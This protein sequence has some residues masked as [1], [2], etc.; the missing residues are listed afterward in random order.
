MKAVAAE[1]LAIVAAEYVA[2]YRI[3]LA[4]SDGTA[5]VVDFGPFLLRAHNPDTTDYRDLEKFKSFRIESGD[6]IWGDY[7]MLFPLADL[8]RGRI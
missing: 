8:H 4:F 1:P 5:R 7:Q 3:R 2:G 6:L